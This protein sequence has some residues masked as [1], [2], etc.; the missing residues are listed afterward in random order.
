VVLIDESGYC[1][2]LSHLS[3]DLYR[4]VRIECL[5]AIKLLND[6]SINSFQ[7]LFLNNISY[8]LQYDHI[9]AIK[10]DRNILEN[11]C[12]RYGD[13]NDKIN[14]YNTPYPLARKLIMN[15]MR[16]GLGDRV[17]SI[18]PLLCDNSNEL[19]IGLI[20][21]PENAF[22]V[23]DKGP[24]SNQP[25]AEN[26]RAFWGKKAEIRR[27][28]DGSITESLLWC[29]ATA[30]IGEKRLI[31][32]KIVQFLL[33]HHFNIANEKVNYIANQFEI[34]IRN[35]FNEL[36][37]TNEERSLQVIRTFDEL[38]RQL[39]SLNDIPL[40]IVSVLG[41]DAVF[42]YTD[43]TPPLA[44]ASATKKGFINKELKGRFLAPKVLKG[45][46]QLATSGKWP[47]DID[48]MKRIKAAFY[49]DIGAKI[50]SQYSDIQ[51]QVLHDHI[52]VLK[53]KLLFR[54]KIVHPK[55]IALAKEEISSVN[56]L[57]KIYR[58][59]A[60]S[61]RMEYESTL[62]PKLTSYLHG[63]H[64]KYSSFGPTVAIAKRWLYSQLIDP[65]LWPDECTELIIAEMFLKCNP[66][67]P[68]IQ[69]QVNFFRFLTHLAN[70]NHE[71]DM[72]VVNFNDDMDQ[73]VLS[74]LEVKFRK[75]RK[76]FPP[77]FIVTSFD[78]PHQYGIWSTASPIV[79]IVCRVQMLAQH[80]IK[81]INENFT[82]LS[83]STVKDLFTPS[84]E[85]YDLIITLNEKFVKRFDIVLHNF[86][87]FKAIQYEKK[88]APP[89]DVDLVSKFL[90]ELRDAFD[91]V[92]LFFYD[93]ICARKIA[94]L[95]K[96]C[97]QETRQFAVSH[98]NKCKQV[99]DRLVVNVDAILNDIQIIG[100]GLIENIE[101]LN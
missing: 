7:Q 36:I 43:V 68:S 4:R 35:I 13:E 3:V 9:A 46:I 51:V 89:A 82:K 20:L 31:C 78:A 99:N 61:M 34:V 59:N 37:E 21:N 27:F 79:N 86:T 85:G 1:N 56:N 50:K 47:D 70:F 73:E 25:E 17:S 94:V 76:N 84:L 6:K 63:L 18:V 45:V 90:R 64:H 74:T 40:E 42:R 52:E 23:V 60:T 101:I 44:N 26:F 93:P 33:K 55:E 11:I 62:L 39:R 22:N 16:K 95:W 19:C 14:Y 65:F 41:I 97:V 98:L 77:L 81:M 66:A 8:Y 57:T 87:N 91:D 67:E 69:P 30:P 24:Q 38:S 100:S 5:S 48:A 96:P 72:I 28:K 80:S 92:A 10:C 29:P 83:G 88:P 32:M 54:F 71:N 15:V 49:I 53:E 58:T 12:N 75:C 2:I